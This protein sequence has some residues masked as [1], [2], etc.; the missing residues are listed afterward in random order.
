[1]Y[2]FLADAPALPLQQS[3]F[4]GSGMTLAQARA[5]FEQD[6]RV[7][8]LM[9]NGA[10]S[11][12]AGSIGAAWELGYG[13]WPIKEAAPTPYHLGPNG[14]LTPEVPA[15]GEA[16]YSADPKGRPERTLPGKAE[17]D[18][19]KAQPRYT[20]L[21]VPQGKGLGFTTAPLGQ[22]T[23]IAGSSSLDLTLKSTANDTDLQ[24]TLSEV[25][26]DGAETYVQNGWLRASHRKL[27]SRSTALDAIPTHLKADAQPLTPGQATQIRVPIFPVAHAFRKDSRI[28]VTITAPGGDRPRWNFATLDKASTTNTVLFGGQSKL[29][30]GVLQGATA[31][32]TP[33]PAPTA[34][35]GEPSR[36]YVPA[37]NGG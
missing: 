19:W 20:W 7:R 17:G 15:A 2:Q 4:A 37:A 3:R 32:G 11:A 1:L 25:R 18:A 31:Q 23:V 30:L 12:G 28:R 27:A 33:F 14:T 5:V 34:L 35:R 10:S 36:Q 8:L 21:P 9:D 6:P 29:V 13:S 24:V 16:S 22:D 26:P